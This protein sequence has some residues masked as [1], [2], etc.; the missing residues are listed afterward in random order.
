MGIS[1][2]LEARRRGARSVGGTRSEESGGDDVALGIRLLPPKPPSLDGAWDAAASNVVLTVGDG[3]DDSL[4]YNQATCGSSA[5]RSIRCA[6][7]S[8]LACEARL[9]PIPAARL[10]NDVDLGFHQPLPPPSIPKERAPCA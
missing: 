1:K 5:C 8:V 3:D 9:R 7:G 10:C 4:V 6:R 2:A